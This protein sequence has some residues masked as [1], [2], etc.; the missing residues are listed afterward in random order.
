L[1][2]KALETEW[3][4]LDETDKI[5]TYEDV[6]ELLSQ[7]VVP[8]ENP[9]TDEVGMAFIGK[10]EEDE[11][12]AEKRFYEFMKSLDSRFMSN[13]LKK[14]VDDGLLDMKFMNNDFVFDL[15]TKGHEVVKELELGE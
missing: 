15:T 12:G 8:V 14:L 10:D 7:Y 3:D 1:L 13:S 4:E 2:R 6:K 11:I 9:E 5:I